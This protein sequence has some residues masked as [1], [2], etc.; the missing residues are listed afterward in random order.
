[1][2]ASHDNYSHVGEG[3]MERNKIL[4]ETAFSVGTGLLDVENVATYQQCIRAIDATP[5][6]QLVEEMVMLVFAG[7]V[8]IHHLP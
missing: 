3:I 6:F 7:V 5:F 2:I 1:M 4:V 8:L